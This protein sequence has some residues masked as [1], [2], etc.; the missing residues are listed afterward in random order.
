MQA[1]LNMKIS[2]LIIHSIKLCVEVAFYYIILVDLVP[3][4]QV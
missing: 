2:K 3:L 4:T 1:F